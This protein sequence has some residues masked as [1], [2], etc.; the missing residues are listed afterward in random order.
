MKE[1][2]LSLETLAQLLAGT[3]DYESLT[4]QVIPHLLERCPACRQRYQEILALQKEVGHWDERVA[5]FEGRQAPELYAVLQEVP[6]DEQLGRVLDDETFQTWGFCQLLIRKSLEQ[7][8][9]EPDR[10]VQS[11]ELAVRVAERLGDAYDPHWVRDL[12]ARARLHLGNARRVLGEIH[13]AEPAFLDADR[14]LT[15][16][17]TGNLAVRAEWLNFMASLRIDQRRLAEALDLCEK[18]RAIYQELEDF[19]ALTDILLKT[20]KTHHE[21]GAPAVAAETLRHADASLGEKVAP[22]LRLCIRHNL[23]LSLVDLE[24]FEEAAGLLPQVGELSRE[25][26]QPLDQVRLRWVE[27]RVSFGLHRRDAAEALYREVRDQFERRGMSYDVALVSLDLA[28]LLAEA[29]R[30]EELKELAADLRAA[31]EALAVPRETL[32]AF[33]LFEHACREERVTAQLARQL[34]GLLEQNRHAQRR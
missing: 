33:L 22:R 24:R 17:M 6:F 23:L 18:A 1:T 27:G 14:L 7:S 15:A 31:F 28:I 32:A 10:A 16:S 4:Q 3:L 29:G 9:A 12:Q 2:H 25:V 19:E 30:S 26:G 20:A 13:S 5:V 34:G 21:A 8:R 11:A